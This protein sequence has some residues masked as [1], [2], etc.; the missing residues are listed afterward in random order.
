M[1]KTACQVYLFGGKLVVG[2]IKGFHPTYENPN[3]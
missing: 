1:K 3:R 2:E